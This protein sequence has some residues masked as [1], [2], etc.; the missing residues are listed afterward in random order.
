MPRSRAATRR[1]AFPPG[2]EP[3]VPRTRRGLARA[4]AA[5]LRAASR[6]HL[7]RTAAGRRGRTRRQMYICGAVRILRPGAVRGRA[8]GCPQVRR[9]R[10]PHG[11]ALHCPSMTCAGGF[12]KAV[13]QRGRFTR[14]WPPRRLGAGSAIITAHAKRISVRGSSTSPARSGCAAI[15]KAW[16]SARS[17][18]MRRIRV[19]PTPPT[20]VRC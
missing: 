18:P 6:P 7:T 12:I 19:P 2:P 10:T 16:R 9:S 3:A 8:D 20:H 15:L 5:E 14:I 11:T 17:K 4:C 1:G 13:L